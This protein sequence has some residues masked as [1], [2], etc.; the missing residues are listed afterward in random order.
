[1]GQLDMIKG[2]EPV[3]ITPQGATGN[4]LEY[5]NQ[6]PVKPGWAN[7]EQVAGNYWQ[8]GPFTPAGVYEVNGQEF[9]QA[10][11]NWASVMSN[12]QIVSVPE[13]PVDK[14]T[15]DA[16]GGTQRSGIYNQ[17]YQI[18]TTKQTAGSAPTTGIYTGYYSSN[19]EYEG[20]A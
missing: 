16:I 7:P 13:R 12:A 3:N 9:L 10:R 8:M 19:G 20:G 4:P 6:M 14:G 11:L 17:N 15:F 2:F 1:M 18:G 5:Y